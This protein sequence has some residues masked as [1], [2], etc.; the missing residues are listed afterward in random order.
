M[1]GLHAPYRFLA[2]SRGRQEGIY[3]TR[4]RLAQIGDGDD[5]LGVFDHA[6]SIGPQALLQELRDH[7]VE[8]TLHMARAD[9]QDAPAAQR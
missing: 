7:D 2:G 5:L 1:G 6:D 3:W 8:G 9:L 4:V